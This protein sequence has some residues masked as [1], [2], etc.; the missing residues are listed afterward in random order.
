MEPNRQITVSLAA[1]TVEPTSTPDGVQ[2]IEGRLVDQDIRL[3][4]DWKQNP[5][6]VFLQFSVTDT[7]RGLS[8]EESRSLFTRFSQA[9]PRTHIHYGGSGL[10]LFISRRL[11]ELQGGSI[12]LISRRKAGSTFS[13]YIKAR[14]TKPMLRRKGSLPTVFPEDIRHRPNTPL[15]SL[16]QLRKAPSYQLEH[17]KGK[18]TDRSGASDQKPSRRSPPRSFEKFP[19]QEGNSKFLSLPETVEISGSEE[20][21]TLQETLHVLVVEDNLVNQRVLAQQLRTL[22]CVVSVANHG[23]EALDILPRT[24]RWN[25]EDTSLYCARQTSS[26]ATASPDISQD[27]E[28]SPQSLKLHLVLMDWE[29]PVMNGLIAV[30]Q[31][32][33]FEKIG[34]MKGRVPV[35]GVTA[36]VRQQQIETALAAGMDD[37]VSKPFRVAELLDRMRTLVAKMAKES[38]EVVSG[39]G[40]GQE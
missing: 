33:Q 17:S 23:R 32:R 9:S 29:M 28:E 10:G 39:Q 38:H 20:S 21:G 19:R 25:F 34:L 2:F 3:Q 1:S 14:R 36:N 6:P 27:D 5:E 4:D 30:A 35:I 31:I 24:R 7:G 26:T 40:D 8:E 11:T 12:G 22:G 16:P 13:F 15:I 18:Y 37:V